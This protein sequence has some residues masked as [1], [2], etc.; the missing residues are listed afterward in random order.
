[1]AL[2]LCALADVPDNGSLG[3]GDGSTDSVFA[4][5]RGGEVH[6]YRNRCPHAGAPLNWM[7][8]RFLDRT[9]EHII[10][11]AHGALFDI[12]SGACVA[13]PCPGQSLTPVAFEVRDDGELWLLADIPV[14]NGA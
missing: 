6:V 3:F 14:P 10:C 1:M 12:A 13:G 5:R 2:R 9:R 7:P 8:H 11:S 4:V